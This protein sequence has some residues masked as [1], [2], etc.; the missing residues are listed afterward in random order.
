MT[1]L[2]LKPSTTALPGYFPSAAAIVFGLTA[3]DAFLVY[4]KLFG[5]EAVKDRT[6][7]QIQ[8]DLVKLWDELVLQGQ[9]G[10]IALVEQPEEENRQ[11][12]WSA[13][14]FPA[15]NPHR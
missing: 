9:G 10:K 4:A 1:V 11:R 14:S 12:D 6:E 8:K 13:D 15:G 3:S 2:T 5:Y 7:T